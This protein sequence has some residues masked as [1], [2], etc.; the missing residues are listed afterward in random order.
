MA[1]YIKEK[2]AL[3]VE[4]VFECILWWNERAIKTILT[5]QEFV[6]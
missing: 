2:E 3:D 1:L 4:R 5:R 6:K